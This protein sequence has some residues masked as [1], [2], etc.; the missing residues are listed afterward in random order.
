MKEIFDFI[1]DFNIQNI[2]SMFA[3][4]WYFSRDV[5]LSIDNLDKDVRNMNTRVTRL[6]GTIYGKDIY[7]KI[8]D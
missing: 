8:E 2:L 6:E 3:I 7:N 4:C 5:K 1:R